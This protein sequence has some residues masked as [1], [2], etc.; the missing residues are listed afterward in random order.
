MAAVERQYLGAHLFEQR[1]GLWA[2]ARIVLPELAGL[3]FGHEY[4][5]GESGAVGAQRGTEQ[6]RLILQS[7]GLAD[8]HDIERLDVPRLPGHARICPRP[9]LPG[10]HHKGDAPR[11]EG[12]IGAAIGEGW[13]GA[14][15]RLRRCRARADRQ[16]RMKMVG[17]PGT[18]T[19]R[20]INCKRST[21]ERSF[22]VMSHLDGPLGR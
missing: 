3:R 10:A 7:P 8:D 11:A 17:D 22:F 15:G 5:A 20:Q 12:A 4:P 18:A 6:D 21:L 19:I 9:V 2:D 14:D 13:R 1:A 16:M